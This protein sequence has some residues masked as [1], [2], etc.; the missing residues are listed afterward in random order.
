MTGMTDLVTGNE[1]GLGQ[2]E[3]FPAS[4]SANVMLWVIAA[5][6]VIGL[7]WATF[8]K[9]ERTVYASGRVIPSSK[10]QVVSNLEGGVI[11]EILVKPGQIVKKGDV[12]VRLSPTLTTAE[13]GSNIA[14]TEALRAKIIR[15]TAEV[16]GITPSFAGVSPQAA[17]IELAL[18][19]ARQSE[20]SGLS[21]AGGARA[22]QAERAVNEAQSILTARQSN[23]M[24]AQQEL[25]MLRPLAGRQIVSQLDYVKAENAVKVA[26]SE[27]S[28]AEASVARAQAA[29]A[30]AR[31]SGGQSRSDWLSRSGQE[32]AAAQGEL[33]ARSQSTPA[34][35]DRVDRTTIRATM[36]GRVNR[37]LITTVGGSVSPG[38]PMVEITPTDDVLYVEA[39]VRPQDIGNIR[40]GQHTKVEITAYRS[41]VFGKLEGE[42]VTISPDVVVH[43][44]TGEAFYTV[45]VRTTSRLTDSTGKVLPIGS[46]MTANVSLL[47]EERSVLSYIFTPFTQL[48]ET[49]FRE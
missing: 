46:G 25:D 16:R 22:I 36:N 2:H 43:E 44:K 24:A 6:F 38:A 31:A 1:A 40:I 49:A 18:Y 47:G 23:L 4:K 42:V 45:E 8:T 3:V 32:L 21:G 19:R 27:V 12:L 13:Y 17:A 7:I 9:L 14:T 11:Q 35:A 20:L 37:V 26:R 15:L 34:L 33:N 29:V 10:M 5:F 28:A 48:S 41:A 39:A 30:E